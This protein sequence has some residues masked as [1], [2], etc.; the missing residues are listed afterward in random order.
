[1]RGKRECG[2]NNGRETRERKGGHGGR[3]G[4]TKG[5]KLSGIS[6]SMEGE[7]ICVEFEEN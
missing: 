6:Y 4:R 1:M 5:G 3:Q 2:D 7:R